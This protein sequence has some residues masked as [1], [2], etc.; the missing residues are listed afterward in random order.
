MELLGPDVAS[1]FFCLLRVLDIL[2]LDFGLL[3][4]WYIKTI[5]YLFKNF[6]IQQKIERKNEERREAP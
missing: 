3:D 4:R 2:I 1:L 5:N 6:E